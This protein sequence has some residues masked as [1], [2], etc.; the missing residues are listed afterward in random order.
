LSVSGICGCKRTTS[1][2]SGVPSTRQN[3]PDPS[4]LYQGIYDDYMHGNLDVAE[5]RAAR[6]Y[7]DIS[8]E[9]RDWGWRFRL[10]QAE[11]CLRLSRTQDAMELLSGL[12]ASPPDQSDIAIK[13]NLLSAL[14]NFR[15]E[16]PDVAARELREARR[17]AE[18]TNS[19]LMGELLRDEGLVERDSGHA[20][21]ALEKFQQ[22]LDV[23]R[24]HG[25]LLVQAS[26][27]VDI[28]LAALNN[29]HFEEALEIT[30]EAVA[31]TRSIQARRQLQMVIG[32][33]GWAYYSLGDFERALA[34]FQEA[35]REALEFG[36]A[37]AQVLWLQNAGLAAYRLG[38]LQQA[39]EYD[40]KALQKTLQLPRAEQLIPLA[41]I[42][43][44]LALL[45]YQQGRYEEARK[46][47]DSA[48]VASRDA[49][50]INQIAYCQLVQ[51][52]LEWRS[53]HV[54]AAVNIFNEILHQTTDVDVRTETQ[55]AMANLYSSRHDNPRAELWYN[56]SIQT[57][58]AK[59]A[60]IQSEVLRL[61]T[62]GYGDA[63]YRDYANFLIEN[64]R[65][66]EAL[67]LLDRS[68]ARTLEEGL[69]EE[70]SRVPLQEKMTAAQAVA[71]RL[72]ATILFYSLGPEQSHLWVIARDQIQTLEIPKESDIQA[73]VGEY[74]KAIQKSSD[75]LQTPSAAAAS[76]YDALLKPA[77]NSIPQGSRVFIIPDGALHGLNFETLPEPTATGLR[78]WIEHATVTTASSIS[79]LAHSR[80]TNSEEVGGRR[81]LLIGDPLPGRAEFEPLPNAADE[82]EKVR[83]HFPEQSQTVLT[84][85]QA[86]PAAYAGSHPQEYQYIHFVAHGTASRLVPLDSAV[87]LSPEHDHPE[88]FKLYARDIARQPLT[89]ELVTISACYGS[90]IRTYAGEGLVGLAWVFLRA[91]SHNV[92][93]AL[94]Q[95]S[96]ASTPLLMDRLYDGIQAGKSPDMALREA[97]LTLIHSSNVYRKPFYW[98]AFQ[99]YSGS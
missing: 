45:L 88:S 39:R 57:F 36:Q 82:I 26:D 2:G 77:A 8:K 24:Q 37:N 97:K 51:G 10:L 69:G 95:A 35:E 94:W 64:H 48:L 80:S 16:K 67:A 70:V 19:R 90:G 21:K 93:G 83:R 81:L 55:D 50:D 63:V 46:F 68:R 23:A 30:Q 20:D 28:S 14:A 84:R 31:F 38:Q 9:D 52:L 11:V 7:Q 41:R 54:V 49:K 34:I 13:F 47:D 96:D 53:N 4:A 33:M 85:S 32:N 76:L 59:R 22:S 87:V 40:E 27:F 18:A 61:T 17:Q 25:E 43:T 74:Q 78:Y 72:N 5:A 15:L 12:G 66:N 58:E 91:G 60:G 98:G 92:I 42:Q 71:R 65:S 44:N 79:L 89:A 62:F 56:R 6:A 3:H 99:L 73:W 29:D 86:V 1:S 75:P